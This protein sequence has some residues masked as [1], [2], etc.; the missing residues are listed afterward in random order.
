MSLV[1]SFG[2]GHYNDSVT[3]PVVIPSLVL[4]RRG[5]FVRCDVS[6]RGDAQEELCFVCGS[7]DQSGEDCEQWSYVA[8]LDGQSFS[9]TDLGWVLCA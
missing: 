8:R 5:Q 9:A 1:I 3:D 6:G 2:R 7:L 4:D